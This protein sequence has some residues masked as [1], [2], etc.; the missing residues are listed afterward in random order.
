MKENPTAKGDKFENQVF[1]LF[2]DMLKNE[3]LYISGKNSKIFKKKPYY[4]KTR[5][6]NI[7]TDISIETYLPGV[8]DYSILT[9]IECRNLSKTVPID[10]IE[11]FDSKLNQIGE[12]NTK[13]I[14]ISKLGFQR[15]T[16][17]FAKSKKISLVRI[18]DTEDLQWLSYRKDRKNSSHL[19]SSIEDYLCNEKPIDYNILA[20]NETRYY[21]SLPDLLISCDVID[22][23][24]GNPKE[25]K[26]PFKTEEEIQK[27]IDKY[28]LTKHY[29]NSQLDCESLVEFLS[30]EYSIKFE[31]KEE[32]TSGNLGKILFDPLT[33]YVSKHIQDDI[34]R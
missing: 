5:D 26:I 29:A 13:G 14:L 27:V 6:G 10:D 16:L 33:I 22:R 15:S 31:F 25:I 34:F 24:K 9:I 7:I 18:K 30:S 1:E 11:E 32:L 8:D 17:T 4:S 21:D 20:L 3:D 23:F 12:H 2:S 28:L 19:N